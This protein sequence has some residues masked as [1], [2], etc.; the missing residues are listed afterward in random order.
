MWLRLANARIV[1][2]QRIGHRGAGG[3]SV[4]TPVRNLPDCLKEWGTGHIGPVWIDRAIRNLGDLLP[5]TVDVPNLPIDQ[6]IVI[7][8]IDKSRQRTFDLSS[9]DLSFFKK[10]IVA[11]FE[12][13][14][15]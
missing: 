6:L 15:D 12:I 10:T 11:V 8:A 1:D 13:I 4:H 14:S 7:H 9:I 3:R 5:L 2:G